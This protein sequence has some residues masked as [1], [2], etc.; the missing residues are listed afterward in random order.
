V[1]GAQAAREPAARE[2]ALAARVLAPVPA[3]QVV[4]PRVAQVLAQA[5][6]AEEAQPEQLEQLAQ[7]VALPTRARPTKR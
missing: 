1:P 2:L 6:P 5:Q 7:P 3:A 4:G